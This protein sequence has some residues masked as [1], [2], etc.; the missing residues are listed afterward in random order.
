MSFLKEPETKK[1]ITRS[2]FTLCDPTSGI[3]STGDILVSEP[4]GNEW[5]AFWISLK[6]ASIC[7]LLV[8]APGILLGTLLARKRFFGD[9]LI[10]AVV[11]LPLVIP[12]V[13]TGYLALVL[14][15]FSAWSGGLY[16]I[17][18]PHRDFRRFEPQLREGK[19][20]FIV[21]VDPEQEERLAQLVARHPQLQLAGTGRATPR[22]IVALRLVIRRT[23][24]SI[25]IMA[26]KNEMN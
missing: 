16:G 9:S 7:T 14:L 3:G 10:N 13:V 26:L 23:G 4:V 22:W 11:H 21:D 18:V 20:V 25:S 8:A 12:P 6:V 17:Q 2:G 1:I 19:H 5:Q 24:C 15:G